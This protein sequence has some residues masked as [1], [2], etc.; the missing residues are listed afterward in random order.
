MYAYS[1]IQLRGV[2]YAVHFNCVVYA[3]CNLDTGARWRTAWE[4]ASINPLNAPF[5]TSYH[6]TPTGSA[7]TRPWDASLGPSLWKGLARSQ[8]KVGS[9]P[10]K[11]GG[12]KWFLWSPAK[13]RTFPEFR[14]HS[15]LWCRFDHSPYLLPHLPPPPSRPKQKYPFD[16]LR[17]HWHGFVQT[18]PISGVAFDEAWNG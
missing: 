2:E 8:H 11:L 7:A 13:L 15:G 3:D 18:T 12:G 10:W 16:V 6:T 9:G 14:Q 5:Q 1:V 17:C 4:K